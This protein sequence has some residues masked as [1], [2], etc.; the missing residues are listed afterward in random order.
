MKSIKKAVLDAL[1]DVAEQQEV[2]VGENFFDNDFRLNDSGFDSLGFAILVAELELR[3]GYDP[4][5]LLEEP[6]F[7]KTTGEL[8]SLYER[9]SS[10][11]K[12]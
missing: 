11:A 10:H 8:I 12:S 1:K 2:A 5:V 6:F 9:F 3:L 7:P 4:F